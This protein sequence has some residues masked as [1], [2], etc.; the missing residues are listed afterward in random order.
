MVPFTVK[1]LEPD[2]HLA[3]TLRAEWSGILQWA[4]DGCLEWQKLGGLMAPAAVLDMTDTYLTAQDPLSQWI[5]DC[6]VLG[7]NEVAVQG[8]LYAS[9]SHH[10]CDHERLGKE[11]FFETLES[12]GLDRANTHGKRVFRG[13][14]LAG[15]QDDIP[16]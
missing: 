3:D 16:F 6:C 13:I 14:G 2:I 1:V 9:Y 15:K 7:K 8:D 5:E 4:I 12:R 10:P 11:A